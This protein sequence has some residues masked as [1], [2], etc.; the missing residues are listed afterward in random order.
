MMSLR[1]Q[2]GIIFIMLVVAGS[3]VHFLR[4]KRI[5]FRYALAWLFVDIIIIVMAIFPQAM[6]GLSDILG[7]ASPVNMVLFV[8]LCLA[9]VVI[10][11]LSMSVSRLADKVR[12]LSQEIAIIRKDMFDG[13]N[14]LREEI[15]GNGGEAE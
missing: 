5:D 15:K 3:I 12:K 9:L 7:V 2:L 1:L 14:R 11:S 8:G 10:F 6:V 4:R 13:D